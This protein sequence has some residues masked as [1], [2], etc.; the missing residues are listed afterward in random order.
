MSKE[1]VFAVM[2]ITLLE[3]ITG[4]CRVLGVI[5]RSRK[6]VSKLII[7]TSETLQLRTGGS[8]VTQGP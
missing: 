3:E 6:S 8:G 4:D 1:W 2:I 7:V 5:I